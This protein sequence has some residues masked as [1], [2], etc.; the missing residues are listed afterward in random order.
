MPALDSVLSALNALR[1]GEFLSE[2]QQQ[3]LSQWGHLLPEATI[4]LVGNWKCERR[5]GVVFCTWK[6][7]EFCSVA[8]RFCG[9]DI[10]DYGVTRTEV[11]PLFPSLGLSVARLLVHWRRNGDHRRFTAP[12]RPVPELRLYIILSELAATM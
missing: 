4:R 10:R 7:I 8:L 12:Y 9:R 5:N 11:R 3:V 2:D 1:K 6:G